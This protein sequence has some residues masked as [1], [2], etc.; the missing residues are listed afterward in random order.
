MRMDSK[1]ANSSQDLGWVTEILPGPFSQMGNS[2]VVQPPG[3]RLF[4]R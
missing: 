1:K 2:A 3:Q 4:Q